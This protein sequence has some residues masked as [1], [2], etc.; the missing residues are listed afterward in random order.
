MRYCSIT[1]NR[2][3]E[4]AELFQFCLQQLQRMN[5]GQHVTNAYLMNDR[6]VSDQC[7]LVPRVKHGIEMAIRDGFEWAFIIES[8]DAYPDN[9]FERFA[10]YL[11]N[12]DFVGDQYST[13]YHIG[14]K[15]YTRIH[16]PGRA[17]LFTTGIRLSALSKFQWPADSYVFLDQPLWKYAKRFRCK[18]VDS[19][20][21][22]IKGHKAGK[23]GGKGHRIK[24]KTDDQNLFFLRNKVQEHHFEFY[25][26]LMK[27]L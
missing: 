15:R 22:G 13:Y 3:G 21:I 1:P 2:G 16:H 26:D 6:A 19:G 12:F 7:D 11:N 4:R 25:S 20:A 27:R 10:P 9:Y 23:T 18:F 24:L 14:D 17:S 5:G 8:D